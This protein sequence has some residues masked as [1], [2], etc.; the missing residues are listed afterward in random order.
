MGRGPITDKSL[1]SLC[2]FAC[3]AVA[4]IVRANAEAQP[5][6]ALQS[7]S[8]TARQAD[9]RDI[10]NQVSSQVAV[11]DALGNAPVKE[12]TVTAQ[13]TRATDAPAS[14]DQRKHPTFDMSQ[15]ERI[16]M[17]VWGSA[18][19]SGDYSIDPSNSISLPRI[20]RIDV[21]G[22]TPAQLEDVLADKL[23]IL[24]RGDVAVSIEVA[25]FRPY[26]IS[27]MVLRS[28]AIEWRPGLKVIQAISL[29]G[30]IM[31]SPSAGGS[32]D[33]AS[34]GERAVQ[35][36]Q[37]QTQL[38]FALAQLARLKAEKDRVGSVETSERVAALV[39]SAPASSQE[40]LATLMARQNA[41]LAEQQ[42]MEDTQI[43]GLQKE[44]EAA[45][46]ELEEAESQQQ[47]VE[48]QLELTRNMLAD[49][50][51][52]KDQKLV[53]KSRYYAQRSDLLTS[54]VRFAETRSLVARAK[55]RVTGIDQQIVT[56][57]QQRRAALNERIELL[58][59]EVAQLEITLSE[60]G[61][62]SLSG[63]DAAKFAYHIARD[64]TNGVQ[65]SAAN[66]FA[67]V[68]PGDVVI[69]SGV[70]EARNPSVTSIEPG[71]DPTESAQRIL[72]ASATVREQNISTR[73]G[74]P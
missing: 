20:G 35:R 14:A 28:G 40:A 3:L 74:S 72:E 7:A 45:V 5:A 8:A 23:R 48:G 57:P 30:G 36:H 54:E 52:L 44:R 13:A 67:E 6:P 4:L 38:T 32:L 58:E 65:T 34:G 26:Y 50:E 18:E 55:A 12:S 1:I 11:S 41:M 17:R 62:F 10:A 22:M 46:R 29:A 61:Q 69:V 2:G 47:A 42:T 68:L 19:L 73:I 70:E 49:V 16:T 21:A 59:R 64:G 56:I 15:V 9:L 24:T 53:T 37:S 63:G 51:R 39:K 27:G 66:L 43:S 25:R 60:P 31:R 71:S 33:L